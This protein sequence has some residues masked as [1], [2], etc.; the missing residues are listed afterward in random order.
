MAHEEPAHSPY[1]L[2]GA[3]A[4]ETMGEAPVVLRCNA[5]M[6]THTHTK[7]TECSQNMGRLYEGG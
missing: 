2:K 6:H 1:Q 4:E 5:H 7:E 3:T